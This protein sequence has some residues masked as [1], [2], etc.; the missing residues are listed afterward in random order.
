MLVDFLPMLAVPMP[1][2]VSLPVCFPDEECLDLLPPGANALDCQPRSD[3]SLIVLPECTRSPD[4][5]GDNRQGLAA[6]L[7]V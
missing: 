2:I 3:Y 7:P 5:S 4:N 1:W 6:V